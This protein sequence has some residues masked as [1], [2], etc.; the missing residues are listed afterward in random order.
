MTTKIRVAAHENPKIQPREWSQYALRAQK[1]WNDKDR[2]KGWQNNIYAGVTHTSGR[3]LPNKAERKG[4]YPTVAAVD[5]YNKSHGC[6]YING[7][8][9]HEGGDFLQIASDI[10]QAMG[11]G[12]DSSKP[13]ENQWKSVLRGTWK[14]D[15][16]SNAL[17]KR[18]QERWPGYSNPLDLLP[19]TKY[20][21]S[22]AVHLECIPLTKYWMKELSLEPHKPGM[23]FTRAQHESVALWYFDLAKRYNWDGEWWRTPRV[24]GH[25]D[26]TP[27]SRSTKAGGWDPGWLR[28][29]PYFDWNYVIA[30]ICMELNVPVDYTKLP[31]ERKGGQYAKYK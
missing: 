3:G 15:L 10:E 11:V 14:E 12:I 22:Y 25:E 2:P 17:V 23:L 27:L 6:H 8:R 19:G 21:N 26:L 1:T 13:E 9:G 5:H 16:P 24:V 20:V 7:Y 28:T 31:K 18:W 29:S 30:L 4:Q